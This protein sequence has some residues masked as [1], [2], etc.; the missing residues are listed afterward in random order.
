M[1]TQQMFYGSVVPISATRHRESC[2]AVGSEYAFSKK[3]N[4]VPLTAVEF[5]HAAAEYVIVFAGTEEAVMPAVILGLRGN[6]NLY[7][8]GENTWKAKYI[9]AF[10]RRYPFVFSSNDEGKTFTLCIDEGFAGLNKEGRGERLF[11]AEGKRTQFV[12]NVLA[13]L[14]EYQVQFQRTRALCRK[15][16]ELKLL[17]PMRADITLGSGEQV[18][19]TGFM[20]VSRERLKALAA[21]VLA[22][23]A[24]SDELELVYLHLHSTRNFAGLKDRVGTPTGADRTA[25]GP[26]GEAQGMAKDAKKSAK[27]A[28]EKTDSASEGGRAGAKK[29]KSR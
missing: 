17:D 25:A 15:L 6:E 9:P 24:K 20:T 21:E 12:E 27:E 3:V 10:V 11:D 1:A 26:E 23:M 13:F 7:L 29:S 19:L 4:S 8:A 14:Q 5:P 18:S 2:V 28:V 16:K 22:E